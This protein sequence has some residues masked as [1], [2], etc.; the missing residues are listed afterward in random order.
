MIN[1]AVSACELDT[2]KSLYN[3]VILSGGST[4]FEG[5]VNRLKQELKAFGVLGAEVSR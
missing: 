3:N 5:I 4:L 2:K 1:S